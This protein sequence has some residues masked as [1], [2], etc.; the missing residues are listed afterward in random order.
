MCFLM[1]ILARKL[2]SEQPL[3]KITLLSV[4]IV[5]PTVHAVETVWQ[6]SL[7]NSCPNP[8]HTVY[9]LCVFRQLL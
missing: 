2:L 6:E 7:V 5:L 8:S 4:L 9:L 3:F 1:L